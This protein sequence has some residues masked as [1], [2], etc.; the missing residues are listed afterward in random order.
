MNK[1]TL[2]PKLGHKRFAYVTIYI[3]L[4]PKLGHKSS[5]YYTI[6]ITTPNKTHPHK[7][8]LFIVS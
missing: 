4:I 2:I 1:D 6:C 8:I 7:E 3:N 5:T